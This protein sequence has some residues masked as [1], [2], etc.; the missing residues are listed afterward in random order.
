MFIVT[1]IHVHVPACMHVYEISSQDL[2]CIQ[3]HPMGDPIHIDLILTHTGIMHM[4][5]NGG[6]YCVYSHRLSISVSL[7]F[8]HTHTHTHTHNPIQSLRHTYT[9]IHTYTY[10]CTS[11]FSLTHTHTHTHKH[12]IALTPY[13]T[14]THLV[15]STLCT[16]YTIDHAVTP[17]HTNN[18]N[19]VCQSQAIASKLGPYTYTL[20]PWLP[21]ATLLG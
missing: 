15:I 12:K 6:T 19:L 11:S 7:F 9:C 1:H 17:Q 14:Y 8:F 20:T 13:S 18:T 21:T 16:I 5:T 4:Q 3:S 10:T 2:T